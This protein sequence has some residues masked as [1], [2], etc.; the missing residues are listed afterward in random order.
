MEINGKVT[1]GY[2]KAQYFLKQ[3]F[4]K[5]NFNKKCGF[6]PFPGTLNIIIPENQH[7]TINKIKKECKNI[8]KPNEDFGGVKY[9]KATIN[10]K[11]PGAIIFPEKTTHQ[12]NYL[13][14][15]SKYN[16]RNKLNLK[17]E[18]TVTIKF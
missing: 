13:E 14:F 16:L 10:E 8:I 15:I 7:N 9:I 5:E 18:D 4:Y 3:E 2:G 17:D 6:I 11:T 12:I 1:T